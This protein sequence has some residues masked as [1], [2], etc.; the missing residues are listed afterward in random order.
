M[1]YTQ[2]KHLIKPE[3]KTWRVMIKKSQSQN[4]GLVE[5]SNRVDL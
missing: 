4:I 2:Y 3:T 1:A 5:G